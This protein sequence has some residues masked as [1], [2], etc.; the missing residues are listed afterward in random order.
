[1]LKETVPRRTPNVRQ[2]GKQGNPEA[3][4]MRVLQARPPSEYPRSR[5]A[6]IEASFPREARE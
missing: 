3:L 5:L 6:G 1:M 2:E 4:P